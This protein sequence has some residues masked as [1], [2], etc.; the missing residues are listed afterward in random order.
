MEPQARRNVW[1]EHM[2][3]V[4]LREPE[5]DFS[6]RTIGILMEIW[7]SVA[8][9]VLATL[10]RVGKWAAVVNTRRSHAAGAPCVAVVVGG[11]WDQFP[12]HKIAIDDTS[13]VGVAVNPPTNSTEWLSIFPYPRPRFC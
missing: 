6:T 7:I 1:A 10:V 12:A 3:H 9:N 13:R 5:D 4:P 8:T 11:A 2:I